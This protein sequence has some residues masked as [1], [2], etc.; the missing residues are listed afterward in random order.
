VIPALGIDTGLIAGHSEVSVTRR[1][2]SGLPTMRE[3]H[4]VACI[5]MPSAAASL[6]P[7]LDLVAIRVGDEGVG[8]ASAKF[9]P[10]EQLATGA[11]DFVDSRVD[12]SG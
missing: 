8:A 2:G 12:V 7:N 10:P 5:E 11:L 1:V 6:I 3:Y 9:A 4:A